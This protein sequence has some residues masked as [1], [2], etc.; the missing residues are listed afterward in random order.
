M[1]T[2]LIRTLIVYFTLILTMRLMGK[3]QIGELEVSD[4]VTTLLISEI[5]SLPV[6]NQDIP[7]SYALIPILTLMFLEVVSSVI[8]IRFPKLKNLVSTRPKVLIN[9]GVLD[10]KALR[11]MRLS[12]DELM[13]EIRQQGI[14][15]LSQVAFAILEKNGKL[16]I[17]PKS[18]YA[19][20]D[21]EQLGLHP[22]E[23]K[24]MHIV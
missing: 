14:P 20:P 17:L 22:K 9:H 12:I 8:P 13:C 1:T 6:T 3:R 23:G 11:N 15:D 10:Q 16:T 19:Q 5:G 18:L 24:L 4:L 2:I 7:V 21:A